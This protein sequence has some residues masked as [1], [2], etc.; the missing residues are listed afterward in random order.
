MVARA[1]ELAPMLR[2]QARSVEEARRVPAETIQLFREAGFFKVLQPERFGGYGGGLSDLVR[3]SFEIGQACGSTAWC[4]TLGMAHQWFA[5]LF[6]LQGQEEVWANRGTIIAG[7]YAPL[8]KVEPVAGGYS[9]SGRWPYASNCDNSDW[10]ILGGLLPADDQYPAPET[11][12]FLIPKSETGLEDTWFMAGLAGT[13][14]QTV[15]IDRPIFV[16]EHRMIRRIDMTEGRAPGSR[17]HDNPIYGVPFYAALPYS[18]VTPA[19]G[20]ARGAVDA[21]AQWVQKQKA[22]SPA[23]YGALSE[24]SARVDAAW[25]IVRSRVAETEGLLAEGEK[26][27]LLKRVENRR[28]Q[29]FA[30]QLAKDAVDQLMATMGS[31][32]FDLD[33]PVQRHWRDLN[34]AAHHIAVHWPDGK[35]LYG[36]FLTEGEA[37]GMY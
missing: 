36:Q 17:V 22:R 11:G 1:V 31:S 37:K 26:L 12:L 28:D 8:G 29:G 15:V 33:N 2:D 7:V 5:A 6:P 24:A 14:S 35:T 19:L 16:P 21:F 30:V 10:Y 13:G 20:M 4:A 9:V 32:S 3:I 18:I 27:S 34:V 25:N 23:M